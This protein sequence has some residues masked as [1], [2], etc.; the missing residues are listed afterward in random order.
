MTFSLREG[1]SPLDRLSLKIIILKKN[2]HSLYISSVELW[3]PLKFLSVIL[4]L[5]IISIFGKK[6]P[7]KKLKFPQKNFM[8]E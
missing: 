5:L 4:I 7:I 8:V 2:N 1:L 3:N 6:L